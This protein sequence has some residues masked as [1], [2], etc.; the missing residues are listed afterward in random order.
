MLIRATHSAWRTV[1]LGLSVPLM[2]GCGTLDVAGRREARSGCASYTCPD[3]ARCGPLTTAPPESVPAPPAVAP[4]PA[5][6]RGEIAIPSIPLDAPAGLAAIVPGDLTLWR[7]SG[8]KVTPSDGAAV[9][10]DASDTSIT[11]RDL[12]SLVGLSNLKHL[13]LRNTRIT[14]AGLESVSQLDGLEFLGL[15]QTAVTDAGLVFIADLP[16]LR[17]LTLADTA[18]TDSAVDTLGRMTSL[19]GLNLKGTKLTNAGVAFL[20]SQLPDC[21]VVVDEA[22]LAAENQFEHDVSSTGLGEPQ[23]VGPGSRSVRAHSWADDADHPEQRLSRLLAERLNDPQL[24]SALGDLYRE[25]GQLPEAMIAYEEALRQLPADAD[26]RYRLGLTQAEAG[27]WRASRQNLTLALGPAAAEY[28]HAV[29]LYR[30]ERWQECQEAV[31]RALGWEPEL[32]PAIALQQELA[33]PRHDRQPECGTTS[34]SIELVLGALQSTRGGPAATWEVAIE[35]AML[36]PADLRTEETPRST[37]NQA[38][39]GDEPVPVIQPLGA[40]QGDR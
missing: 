4:P 32:A 5:N 39:L 40:A 8:A 23:F 28:N 21:K 35:P 7:Q 37:V 27:D 15:S 1:C 12:R 38:V 31:D 19:D 20:R 36:S 33:S 3:P 22:V 11:D 17:Y 18:L 26:L 2:C 29:I 6:E 25:R 9:T 24:L 34:A 14:D 10:I 30:Q 16:Q 13:N